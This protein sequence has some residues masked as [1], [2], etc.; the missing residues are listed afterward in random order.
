[1]GFLLDVNAMASGADPIQNPT[2]PFGECI[3]VATVAGH[4]LSHRLRAAVNMATGGKGQDTHAQDDFWGR[5]AWLESLVARGMG[6]FDM[7]HPPATQERDPMLLFLAMVWRAVVLYLWHTAESCPAPDEDGRSA[8]GAESGKQV[9]KTAQEMLRLTSK[10]SELNSWKVRLLILSPF[11]PPCVLLS[12][13]TS[14]SVFGLEP[15]L[16]RACLP[17]SIRSR[18]F[19]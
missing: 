15:L 6:I 9:E 11:L 13:S 12:T 7:Q 10:L 18:P 3:V 14:T 2:S 16:T 17:R 8:A 5:H 19:R 1:M 4:V